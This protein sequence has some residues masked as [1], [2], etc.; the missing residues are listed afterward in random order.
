M[1]VLRRCNLWQTTVSSQRDSLLLLLSVL[2]AC[3]NL[4]SKYAEPPSPFALCVS[5][6]LVQRRVAAG[7]IRSSVPVSGVHFPCRA[8]VQ[9]L[10]RLLFKHLLLGL[11]NKSPALAPRTFSALCTRRY[12]ENG[13]GR[14][15]RENERRVRLPLVGQQL[16]NTHQN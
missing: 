10:L 11:V 3:G 9:Y 15:A 6:P 2:D 16:E 7:T 14:R 13:A 5:P 4:S 12:A 1:S 8:F